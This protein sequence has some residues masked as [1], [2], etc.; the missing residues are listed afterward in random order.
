MVYSLYALNT[1]RKI[2]KRI[3]GYA[4]AMMIGVGT[5]AVLTSNVSANTLPQPQSAVMQGTDA[6]FRDGLFTGKHD[7]EQGRL[8]HVSTGR[9]S[10]A[11]DRAR[12]IAGYDSAYEVST[13]NTTNK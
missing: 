6:A 3:F 7:A 11:A 10:S 9:W 1:R 8:H 5:G 2:M 4:L 12:F 13:T